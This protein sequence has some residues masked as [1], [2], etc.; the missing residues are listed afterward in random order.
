MDYDT[1]NGIGACVGVW[2]GGSV[3]LGTA[4]YLLNK[5]AN[6]INGINIVPLDQVVETIAPKSKGDSAQNEDWYLWL[7]LTNK[8]DQNSFV[9]NHRTLRTQFK[10]YGKKYQH[11][12]VH[13]GNFDSLPDCV[14]VLT[15]RSV[16]SSRYCMAKTTATHKSE[17]DGLKIDLLKESLE[18]RIV[19]PTD[20]PR[21]VQ[22]YGDNFQLHEIFRRRSG[23]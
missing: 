7:D 5:H 18:C 13:D 19:G 9:E 12:Q 23:F 1:L 4:F 16:P 14:L 6:G 3:L 17:L 8:G 11:L 15:S 20:D 2:L 10:E 22:L 21:E